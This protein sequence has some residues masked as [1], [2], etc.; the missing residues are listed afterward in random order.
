MQRKQHKSLNPSFKLRLKMPLQRNN[1]DMITS[2]NDHVINIQNEKHNTLG[3]G[4]PK[5]RII[6]HALCITNRE[7]RLAKILIPSMRHL[8]GTIECPT[9]SA[10]MPRQSSDTGRRLH[11]NNFRQITIQ[12]DVFNIHLI[13]QPLMDSSERKKSAN[14]CH[15]YYKGKNL[16]IIN[17]ILLSESPSNETSLVPFNRTIRFGLDFV[18][19]FAAHWICTR[20][21]GSKILSMGMLKCHQF[22]IHC[23][24]PFWR[25]TTS[26]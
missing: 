22:L 20:R 3:S 4:E 24:L 21:Q 9:K 25:L 6:R 7:E 14:R 10:Y 23:M 11:I 16:L 17:T 18:Y 2:D 13:E 8:F 15:F 19:L 5:H 12:E 26:E 1:N